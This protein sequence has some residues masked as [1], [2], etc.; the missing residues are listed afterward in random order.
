MTLEGERTTCANC[1]RALPRRAGSGRHRRYCNAT[2]RSAARRERARRGPAE[3]RPAQDA[4][5]ATG[6][7]EDIDS[8]DALAADLAA[9][10]DS[11]RR[12][13]GELSGSR[14]STPLDAVST[15]RDL[16]RMGD[17][18]QRVAVDRARAAGHTWQELGDVLGTTRQAAFQR[19]G[20]PIDPRTGA[21]MTGATVPGAV[22][23]AL[24]V[25]AD[26]AEGRWREACED[27]DD[28]MAARLDPDRLA[29]GWA[30]VIGMVGSFE[31]IGEPRAY[32]AGDY[33]IVDT[34]LYFEAGELTGRISYDRAGK[35]AGLHFLPSNRLDPEARA[36]PGSG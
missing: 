15:A 25:L 8:M 19:F 12:L 29:A 20:R 21:P 28:T 26:V 34:P 14:G 17:R 10:T 33:T 23:R 6:R 24:E 7:Q 27:F 30:Q 16:M 4:L 9:V 3:V 31:R 13:A 11:A 5:T 36:R 2:C 22:D 35:V 18:L 1:G 32:P